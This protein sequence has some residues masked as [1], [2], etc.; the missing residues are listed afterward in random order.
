M[1]KRKPK[2]RKIKPIMRWEDFN[3]KTKTERREAKL[4]VVFEDETDIF[5]VIGAHL[6]IT[7]AGKPCVIITVRR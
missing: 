1:Q 6:D 3:L 7:A 5:R 4:F 2:P